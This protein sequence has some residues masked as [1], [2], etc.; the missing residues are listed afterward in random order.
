VNLK[1][2]AVLIDAGFL[3]AFL[4]NTV[5]FGTLAEITEAFALACVST[6]DGEEI[7]RVLYYDC[8]PYDGDGRRK[9]HPLD[10]T[11]QPTSP[12]YRNFFN[13]VLSI[14]KSKPYFAVRLGEMS[15]DGWALS[16]KATSEILAQGRQIVADD[17]EPVL[18]Q[19]GV[20]L[21]IGL[22]VALMAK[23]RLIDRIVVV[24]GDS[25]IVP[26]MKVARREGVQVVLASLSHNVKASLR[27]H[28]DLY[29]NVDL[30]SI[31]TG[32][33]PDGLPTRPPS[34]RTTVP[35][36]ALSVPRSPATP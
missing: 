1:R 36:P 30:Q 12:A 3:R 32:L 9:P 18:R 5:G 7:H 33:Y 6:N 25:D 16:D 21:R 23:D 14:L 17:F 13:S 4:P 24:S 15:F 31:I 2:T 27:E 20:D 10:S 29:R 35:Q 26:A 22:D 19:K 34:N 8:P 11:R 28:A